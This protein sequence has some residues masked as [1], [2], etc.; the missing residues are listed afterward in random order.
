MII[1]TW[2]RS[3]PLDPGPSKTSECGYHFTKTATLA[4][5]TSGSR[6][7]WFILQTQLSNSTYLKNC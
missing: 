3:Q 6:D 7:N 2:P 5:A 4:E 1:K